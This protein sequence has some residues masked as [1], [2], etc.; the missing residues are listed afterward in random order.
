[1]K[2]PEPRSLKRFAAVVD[3]LTRAKPEES[4]LRSRMQEA[5]LRYCSDP[6]ARLERVLDALSGAPSGPK[7]TAGEPAK[8]KQPVNGPKETSDGV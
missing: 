1:M 5:G 4:R 6:V 7:M 8:T 3:E 2:E